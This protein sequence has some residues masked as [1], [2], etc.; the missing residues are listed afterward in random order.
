MALHKPPIS[1]TFLTILLLLFALTIPV[2]AQTDLPNSYDFESGATFNYPDGWRLSDGNE[3]L[4]LTSDDTE[5]YV[6]DDAALRA[7]KVPATADEADALQIYYE[8]YHS[9]RAFK[10]AKV[11]PLDIEGRSTVQYD[12]SADD[13]RALIISFRFEDGVLGL[14]EAMS[15][16]G[17]LKETEAVLA[18]AAS[19]V[20]T[21]APGTA[22]TTTTVSTE[23]VDC[24]ISTNVEDTV[25]VRVGPGENRAPIVF[26]PADE[27]FEVLGKAEANDGSLWWKL[28]KEVVAPDKAA[29]EVWVAQNDVRADGNCEAV[30]DVNA[31]PVIP[32]SNVPPPPAGDNGNSGSGDTGVPAPAGSGLPTSGTYNAS[33]GDGTASCADIPSFN[34]LP[35]NRSETYS[36]VVGGASLFYL[37]GGPMVRTG[38]NTFS[39]SVNYVDFDNLPFNRRFT[40]TVVSSTQMTGTFTD[41]FEFDGRLCSATLPVTMNLQ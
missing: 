20:S 34:F 41:T 31:P 13:G 39:G 30:L 33:I 10:P 12:Y 11:E 15:L 25:R 19:F 29:N 1:L 28:D 27:D 21:G 16:A 32:I 35:D 26:L 9:D 23:P 40:L 36:I 18:V 6:L 14:I 8:E 3:R 24:T 5:V 38:G 22:T 17:K 2:A 37:D 4:I 7:I